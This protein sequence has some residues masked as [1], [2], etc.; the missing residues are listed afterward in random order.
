MKLPRDISGDRLVRV[1]Q[2]LG[3]VV[4]R[5]KGSHVR[6][7]HPGPPQAHVVVPMHRQIKVGTLHDILQTVG[8]QRSLS[9]QELIGLL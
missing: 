1:L 9:L 8:E 5:Q 2:D 3:Y 4:V 7:T 6:L